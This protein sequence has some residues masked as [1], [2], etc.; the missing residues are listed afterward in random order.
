MPTCSNAADTLTGGTGAD[1]LWGGLDADWLDGSADNDVLAG[2]DE[3]DTLLGG[4]GVDVLVGQDGDDVIV[5]GSDTDRD[6]L[7][8][9]AGA[10]EFVFG[11]LI[12]RDVV[13]D[14]TPGEDILNFGGT[15]IV[16]FAGFSV[17]ALDRG[18][19]LHVRVSPGNLVILRGV[20]E[21]ELTAGDILFG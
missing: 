15:A 8:G 2:G 20:Q 5:A 1:R 11:P 12:G 14:F 19:D 10:D 3:A 21:Q 6:M 16:D 17:R 4:E 7:T 18:A 13:V 9:G